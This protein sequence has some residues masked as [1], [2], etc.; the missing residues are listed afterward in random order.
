MQG[1]RILKLPLSDISS[2][3]AGALLISPSQNHSHL[4]YITAISTGTRCSF[5]PSEIQVCKLN[6]PVLC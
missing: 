3:T 5:T 4:L 6:T 2:T 1:G